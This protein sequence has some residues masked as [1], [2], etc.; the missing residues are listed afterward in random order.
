L[1]PA[2][3]T[4]KFNIHNALL[5]DSYCILKPLHCSGDN[6]RTLGDTSL[7]YRIVRILTVDES[8]GA[9]KNGPILQQYFRKNKARIQK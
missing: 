7:S 3:R 4:V 1:R 8:W 9:I 5:A 6:Q 2:G